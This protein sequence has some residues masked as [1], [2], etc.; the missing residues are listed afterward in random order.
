MSK[1]FIVSVLALLVLF[2][3]VSCD[4]E[5]ENTELPYIEGLTIDNYPLIETEKRILYLLHERCRP[6]KK[7]MKDL[8]YCTQLPISQE[9]LGWS[10][11]MAG[12]VRNAAIPIT[13]IKAPERTK[14]VVRPN[15]SARKPIPTNPNIAGI[16]L[17]VKNMENTLPSAPGSILV[18]N[19]PVNAALYTAPE[20]PPTVV[21]TANHTNPSGDRRPENKKVRPQTR[22]IQFINATRLIL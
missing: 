22:Y 15:P 17:K 8:E 13:I 14:D 18:C 11:R 12:G 1:F 7:S 9:T 2:I 4:K 21:S 16:R 6:M 20:T 19:K 5:E 3:C 10:R